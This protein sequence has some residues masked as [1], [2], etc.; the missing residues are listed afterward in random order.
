MIIAEIIEI[1]FAFCLGTL[2]L[3]IGG[4]LIVLIYYVIKDRPKNKEK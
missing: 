1:F 4:F 2:F 3:G